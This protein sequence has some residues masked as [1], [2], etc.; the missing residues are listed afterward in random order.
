MSRYRTHYSPA[1]A[2]ARAR[3]GAVM[4]GLAAG[5]WLVGL[6]M[7]VYMLKH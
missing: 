5:M 6:P 3:A 7:L 2:E 4:A 1:R